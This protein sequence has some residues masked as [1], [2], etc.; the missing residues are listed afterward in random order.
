MADKDDILQE[1]EDLMSQNKLELSKDYDDISVQDKESKTSNIDDGS[2]LN[3]NNEVKDQEDE[4]QKQD[5]DLSALS[6]HINNPVS[7]DNIADQE[8][9]V[10][11]G[12]IDLEQK[13]EEHNDA[14]LID[15]VID[16]QVE[17]SQDENWQS[18]IKEELKEF[19]KE[20]IEN[21]ASSNIETND[22][23]EN[24]V[25][26]D[27][28]FGLAEPQAIEKQETETKILEIEEVK[29]K[30]N[31]IEDSSI[32][33]EKAYNDSKNMVDDFKNK[34]KERFDTQENINKDSNIEDF[35]VKMLKPMLKDWLDNNLPQIIKKIVQQEIKK[36][37]K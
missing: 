24:N 31:K 34:V 9:E 5:P 29:D 28:D 22:I 26:L 32:I 16:E 37:V 20:V 4:P 30:E 11:E 17:Q 6:Q 15:E 36:I 21:S 2:I 8:E 23:Q 3:L 14:D 35:V 7:D 27:E 1:V 10:N 13:Q 19:D 25:D 18:S 12:E 33:S